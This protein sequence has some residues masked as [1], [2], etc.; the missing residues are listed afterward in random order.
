[1]R[2]APP[3]DDRSAE[4]YLRLDYYFL[5]SFARLFRRQDYLNR[6][7]F[8]CLNCVVMKSVTALYIIAP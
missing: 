8:S 7:A 1:M 3:R 5:D 6:R 4:K 2:L